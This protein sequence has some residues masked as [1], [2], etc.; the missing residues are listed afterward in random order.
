MHLDDILP[1][2]ANEGQENTLPIGCSTIMCNQPGQVSDKK[3]HY[4]CDGMQLSMIDLLNLNNNLILFASFIWCFFIDILQQEI[5][6]HNEDALSETLNHWY[7]VSAHVIEPDNKEEKFTSLSYAGFLPGYT[8][9]Y[10]HHGLVYSINTLSAAT[11]RSG[12]T[13]KY[14]FIYIYSIRNTF[15]II[16][17]F[18]LIFLTIL[19][20]LNISFNHLHELLFYI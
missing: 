2:V 10:N 9:G 1:N 16:I 18:F 17:I 4:I 6:G 7:L 14:V 13:R 20:N 19:N 12:K 15:I 5:L 11:L 3:K 8:M